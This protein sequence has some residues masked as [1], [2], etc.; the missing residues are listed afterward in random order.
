MKYY[1]VGKNIPGYMPES[2]N[3]VT[4]DESAA[5][6]AAIEDMA[7]WQ[8]GFHEDLPAPG[9]REII[10]QYDEAI[11]YLTNIEIGDGWSDTLPTSTSPHDLGIS[12]WINV[13]N[14]DCPYPKDD[15]RHWPWRLGF[16]EAADG[17]GMTYD[18]YPESPRSVAYDEG[19]TAGEKMLGIKS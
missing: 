8:E 16:V 6:M 18:D 2:D 14:V 4:L 12:F 10:G 17:F 19:R 13:E 7:S 9:A 15:D 5:K 3:Y 1:V 11:A